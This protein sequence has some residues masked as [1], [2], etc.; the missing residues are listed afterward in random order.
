MVSVEDRA[1]R[2]EESKAK[3]RA[4]FALDESLCLYSPQDNLDSL[5][6]P[7]IRDWFAFTH[8][9]WRPELPPARRRILLM[10]PC[11]KTK[12]YVL[13]TEHQRIN[14]ALLGTGFAPTGA[15][16]PRL[17]E[18]A[19]FNLSTLAHPSGV[20]VHRAVISEPL[21]FVPYEHLLDYDVGPSPAHAYDDPGLFEGRGNAVSPW[22]ADSTAERVGATKW[23][24]GANEK[25]AYVEM[26]NAMAQ[27][28]ADTL[29]RFPG[30]FD[31]RIAWVAPGL[32]H[33]SFVVGR[34]ERAAHG[35]VAYRRA[36]EERLA[37]TGV[38]DLLP[39][40]LAID[41][42]PSREA[43]DAALPRLAERLGLSVKQA[44]GP[45]GRGGGDAT[46][47]AL[48]ELLEGLLAEIL[49]LTHAA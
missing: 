10:L 30:L 13:S 33:R 48:P 24:W 20:V 22:R 6:H 25:R 14:A 19:V 46:P 40:E 29:R 36:G 12:P 41:C 44:V 2:I 26:H 27:A 7:R 17:P 32:T 11:T 43:C 45:F 38:N 23:R 16:D 31:A 47:L 15:P 4:P 34:A 1:R 37:L 39:P 8:E 21:G 3:I 42:L 18:E 49:P 35:V 9:R 28:V 5:R